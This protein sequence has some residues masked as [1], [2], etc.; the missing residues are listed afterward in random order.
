MSE[1][2]DRA[3]QQLR[4]RIQNGALHPGA[5]LVERTICAELGMSRTP[6]REALRLLTAEGWV[7]SRPRR[8]MIVT[9]LRP[10]E[11]GEIF[12]FGTVLESFLASLAA[13]KGTAADR[14][15]LQR[16]VAD[17]E[18]ALAGEPADLAAY[19]ELDRDFHALIAHM[20]GN[21][22]LAN[23][24]KAV[25]GSYVLYQAFR[26]YR[27]SDLELSLQQHRTIHQAIAREDSEWAASAMRTHIL[28]SRSISL[29]P[30]GQPHENG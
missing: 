9:R 29:A 14:A 16:V 12:E 1:M 25:M 24:L 2:A 28:S 5:R 3:Y 18:R 20:A 26:H 4:D 8:G 7:T 23:M 30:A 13:R 21:R 22:R 10:E 15:R 6:V 17:M 19:I 11:I 27:R